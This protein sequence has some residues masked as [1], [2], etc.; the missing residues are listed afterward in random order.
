MHSTTSAGL[1]ADPAPRVA[2]TSLVQRRT[3]CRTLILASPTSA[4]TLHHIAIGM[5]DLRRAVFPDQA[6]PLQSTRH[7][8]WLPVCAESAAHAPEELQEGP[9]S[10]AAAPVLEAGLAQQK[11]RPRRSSRL[12]AATEPQCAALHGEQCLRP[13]KNCRCGH[14]GVF[15]AIFMLLAIQTAADRSACG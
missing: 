3:A 2:A 5:Q 8:E 9:G 7:G 15:K 1:E 12:R 10:A 6:D 4:S 11:P 14:A 13:P